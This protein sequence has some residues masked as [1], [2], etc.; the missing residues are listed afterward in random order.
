MARSRRTSDRRPGKRSKPHRRPDRFC[1]WCGREYSGGDRPGIGIILHGTEPVEE[2]GLICIIKME[3]G[4][5][6]VGYR[7]LPGMPFA[8]RGIDVLFPLCGTKCESQLSDALRHW[9]AYQ[10]VH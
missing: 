3:D 7:I 8:E 6:V 9:R 10:H 2:A 5:P 1:G 4:R